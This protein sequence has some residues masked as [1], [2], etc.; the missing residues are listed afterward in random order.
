MAV[1]LSY[2]LSLRWKRRIDELHQFSFVPLSRAVF[3]S[4]HSDT[5]ARCLLRQDYCMWDCTG[6]HFD[7]ADVPKDHPVFIL[8]QKLQK[9]A[10]KELS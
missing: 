2:C 4:G 6:G 7:T 9:L 10:K 5:E 1:C 8:A 3:L